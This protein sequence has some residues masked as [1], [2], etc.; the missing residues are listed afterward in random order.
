MLDGLLTQVILS[1][2]FAILANVQQIPDLIND[3]DWVPS[4]VVQACRRDGP[5]REEGQGGVR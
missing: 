1:W 5:I 3:S 4:H 2:V